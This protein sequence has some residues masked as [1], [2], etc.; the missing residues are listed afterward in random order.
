ML[1]RPLP[2]ETEVLEGDSARLECEVSAG[3]EYEVLWYKDDEPIEENDR[4]TFEDEGDVHALVLE[5]AEEEDESE[6]KCVVC[7][8]AGSV[9]TKGEIVIEEGLSL[10]VIKEGLTSIESDEG[11][12][13]GSQTK[14]CSQDYKVLI[15]HDEYICSLF[16]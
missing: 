8:V 16:F 1:I 11:Q 6:Y 9:E 13:C 4:L 2:E 7:N 5:L 10:P 12:S 14:M 3:S 15:H